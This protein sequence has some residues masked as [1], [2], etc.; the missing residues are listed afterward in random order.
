[1]L[2]DEYRVASIGRLLPVLHGMGRGESLL[3][4]LVR[5]L[6]YGL[7]P[8]QLSDG[9]VATPQPEPRPK[10]LRGQPVEPCVDVVAGHDRTI[11]PTFWNSLMSE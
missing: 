5:V 9:T 1:M 10:R 6:T 3:D 2:R 11:R 8:T 7:R 4:Q